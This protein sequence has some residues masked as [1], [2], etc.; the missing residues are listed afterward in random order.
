MGVVGS[1]PRVWEQFLGG[2]EVRSAKGFFFPSIF[3]L[4]LGSAEYGPHIS[5]LM[6]GRWEHKTVFP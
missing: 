6:F 5:S 3:N 4:T 1:I 2:P